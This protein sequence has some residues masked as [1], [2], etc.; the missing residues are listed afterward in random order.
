LLSLAEARNRAGD[1][2]GA[3][4][5][6]H[7]MVERAR[8]AGDPVGL[9][10]AAL[11]L[12]AVGARAPAAH[13]GIAAL[14]AEAAAALP[15][16]PSALRAR[17]L[18]ALARGR[19]FFG[20]PPDRAGMEPAAREAVQLATAADDQP[21]LATA[22]LAVHDALW[23]PGTAQQRL[24]V[25]AEM[26]EVARAAGEPDL[27]AQTHQLRAAALLELGDPAGKAELTRYVEAAHALGHARGRWEAISRQ[28]TLAAIG[29]RV[30]EAERF[31][32]EALELGRAIGEADAIGVYGT[33]RAALVLFADTP[34]EVPVPPDELEESAPI[35]AMMPVLRAAALLGGGNVEGARG[36]LLG[37]TVDEIGEWY[38]LEWLA[39]TAAVLVPAGSDEQRARTYRRIQPYAGLHA[40]VGGCASYWGAIDHH[41]GS[42]AAAL[43]RRE[44]AITH[45]KAAL[46]GYRR[47]GAPAWARRCG[48]E[49]DR[50]HGEPADVFRLDGG[51]WT[52]RY[53]GRQALLPDAKGMHDLATLLAAPGR[54]VHALQLL[55]RPVPAAAAEPVLDQRAKAAYRARLAELD[56]E[57][58]E[59][60]SWQDP[61]RAAKA[62]AEREA[63]V[64]ELSAAAGLGGRARRLGDEV[65]RARKTVTA[66]IRDALRRI[67]AVHPELAAHLRDAVRTGTSCSYQ[68]P[69]PARWRL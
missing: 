68:P 52:L 7:R 12:H 59:A 51:V 57:I 17:V 20:E 63:L 26:R 62:R 11:G 3:R 8:R 1:A 33:Q 19:W 64:A 22:L 43:G 50:L 25:L 65:E 56:A 53:A 32:A 5:D 30:V 44:Q 37:F 24:A 27:L 69:E 61:H 46:A 48:E 35:P 34:G 18:T 54:P 23:A 49:L 66:R 39:V 38:D 6:Y 21:A 45:L 47:L 58:D 67:D 16:E 2:D 60:R 40:V 10:R 9:A 28:A 4:A 13:A 42:L 41:L 15:A 31:T 14:L 55:G 29:G 36:V